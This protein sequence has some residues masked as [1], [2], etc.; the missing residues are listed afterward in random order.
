MPHEFFSL[1]IEEH[2]EILE[3]IEDLETGNGK[4]NI[5][6]LSKELNLH[7]NGEEKFFYPELMKLKEMQ[8][9]SLESFDLHEVTDRALRKLV[10]FSSADFE[11]K[12]RTKVLK[13]LFEHHMNEEENIIFPETE[14]LMSEDDLYVIQNDYIEYREQKKDVI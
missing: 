4:S 6:L 14:N 3:L 8:E 7:M 2:K 1:L 11:F 10:G 12:V 13:E 5:K 9:F